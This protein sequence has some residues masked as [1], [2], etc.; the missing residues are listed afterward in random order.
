MFN[1][2]LLRVI[3]QY[4]DFNQRELGELV[5]ISPASISLYE[6]NRRTPD[7][8]V[9]SA[10]CDE[11]GVTP[12]YFTGTYRELDE[13][14]CNFR[15]NRAASVRAQRRFASRVSLLSS[16]VQHIQ[17]FVR[18]PSFDVPECPV[19]SP[20]EIEEAA[21]YCREY[22]NLG[23]GPIR[24]VLRVL[25]NAGVIVTQIKDESVQIDAF[26]WFGSGPAIVALSTARG[27]GSRATFSPMHELGH[28]ALHRGDTGKTETQKESEANRF[29]GAFLL[30]RASFPRDF[31]SGGG[32]SLGHLI[33][34][35]K[36]WGVSIAAITYR[37]HQLDLIN[38]AQYRRLMQNISRRGWRRCEP[39][40]PE[41]PVPELLPMASTRYM[42]LAGVSVEEAANHMGWSTDL[43]VDITGIEYRPSVDP[44]HQLRS[45]DEYR[46]RRVPRS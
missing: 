3:R 38:T 37:A 30:P 24:R 14:E 28:G 16:W 32:A 20:E 27:S 7:E 10:L 9:V 5:A 19:K 36:R 11:L 25:E 1:G 4:R 2:E 40:E 34:L 18:L 46:E 13:S 21:D 42:E 41:T 39:A 26:S 29:A 33:D 45:L 8:E 35:K 6:N 12:A 31:W 43:F 23:F 17:Q 15:C 22:W 44:T